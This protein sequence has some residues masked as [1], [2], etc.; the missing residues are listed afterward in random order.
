[1]GKSVGTNGTLTL[2]CA[3]TLESVCVC[4]C[5]CVYVGPGG[6]HTTITERDASSPTTAAH[7]AY[8]MKVRVVETPIPVASFSRAMGSR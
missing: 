8:R 3:R 2:F 5:E 4:V 7:T 6:E 1:M